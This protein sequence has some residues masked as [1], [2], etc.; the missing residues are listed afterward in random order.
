MASPPRSR[1]ACLPPR[2]APTDMRTAKPPVKAADPFY[3]SAAWRALMANLIKQRG[4]RCEAVGCGRS[5]CRV[6]GDHVR[7]LQDG[8]EALEPANVQLLCG[9]CHTAKTARVRA[10]RQAA[11]HVRPPSA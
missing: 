9:S 4:R 3:L 1:L 7:E 6:F 5:G 11:R 10:A 8:G 2:V